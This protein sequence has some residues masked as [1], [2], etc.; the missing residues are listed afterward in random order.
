ME[1]HKY[2][3][4]ELLAYHYM[5]EGFPQLANDIKNNNHHRIVKQ[6]IQLDIINYL[7]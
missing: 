6:F 3:L 4:F 7:R 2:I 5:S 1:K